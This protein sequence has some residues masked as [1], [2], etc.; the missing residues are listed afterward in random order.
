MTQPSISIFDGDPDKSI[1]LV[2]NE[3][4]RIVVN[5]IDFNIPFTGTE[6]RTSIQ[7]TGKTRFITLQGTQ[8]GDGFQGSDVEARLGDFVFEM[9][10]KWVNQNTAPSIELTDSLGT[11]YDVDVIDWQWTRSQRDPNR[12]IWTL[13]VKEA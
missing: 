9:E 11:T 12:L 3:Q 13:V 7:G 8:N 10:D 1:G 4:N 5:Y 6:G 2:V